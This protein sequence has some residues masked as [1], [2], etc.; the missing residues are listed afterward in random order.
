MRGS[1]QGDPGLKLGLQNLIALR[2]TFWKIAETSRRVVSATASPRLPS[3][4]LGSRSG[5]GLHTMCCSSR[6]LCG[7]NP[8]SQRPPPPKKKLGQDPQ[9]KIPIPADLLLSP[10]ETGGRCLG[11]PE[12]GIL[13]LALLRSDVCGYA[14]SG[15]AKRGRGGP[16][17]AQAVGART[18]RISVCMTAAMT[19]V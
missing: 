13:R 11:G 3:T 4:P 1:Q 12:S 15:P 16:E 8:P 10:G 9:R 5:I 14:R 2:E 19:Q 17:F 7:L 18:R 6:G